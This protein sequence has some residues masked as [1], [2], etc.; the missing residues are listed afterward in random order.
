MLD[1]LIWGYPYNLIIAGLGGVLFILA[2]YLYEKKQPKYDKYNATGQYIQ[3]K[4]DGGFYS[5]LLSTVVIITASAFFIG[6]VF[7]DKKTD[8]QFNETISNCGQ[9]KNAYILKEACE[10]T[11]YVN[12]TGFYCDYGARLICED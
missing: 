3:A 8:Y 11:E 5:L 12:D 9:Y 4:K 7:D 1:G 6:I 10:N 2:C